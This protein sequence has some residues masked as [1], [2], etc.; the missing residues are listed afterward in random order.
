[1]ITTNLVVRGSL[2]VRVRSVTGAEIFEIW[3]CGK[4]IGEESYVIKSIR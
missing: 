1:M 4:K 3:E 2:T